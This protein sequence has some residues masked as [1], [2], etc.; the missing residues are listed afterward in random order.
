MPILWHCLINDHVIPKIPQT[1]LVA[2]QYDED[3]GLIPSRVNLRSECVLASLLLN[4]KETFL[5]NCKRIP[6]I[7][8]F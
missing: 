6:E 2:G 1:P 5:Y 3:V 8:V 4:I 7:F